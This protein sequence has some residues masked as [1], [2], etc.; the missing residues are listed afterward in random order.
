VVEFLS[1]CVWCE[2]L[3]LSA[4]LCVEVLQNRIHYAAYGVYFH[5]YLKK[6][7]LYERP[8]DTSRHKEAPSGYATIRIAVHCG[9]RSGYIRSLLRA[10][11]V[12]PIY[13][14]Y[15]CISD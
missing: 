2:V 12:G 15:K 1:K 3:N 6:W 5:G 4:I 8:K 13:Y 14:T 7:A 9:L 11:R 10:Y